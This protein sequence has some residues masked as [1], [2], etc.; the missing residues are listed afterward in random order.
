MILA[1]LRREG[2][3]INHKK[4]HRLWRDEG[5]QKPRRGH[6]KR[7]KKTEGEK[8]IRKAEYPNHVWSYDFVED[9]T[10]N[11]K[12]IRN[13]VIMDEFTREGLQIRVE[14]SFPARTVINTLEWLFMTRAVPEFI[15][16]D[17]GPEFISKAITRWLKDCGV[18]TL[19]I[20]PGSPWENGHLE[21]LNGTFRDECLNRYLFEN[22]AEAQQIVEEFRQEYNEFRPHSSLGYETPGAYARN[23]VRGQKASPSDPLNA[24]SD[25]AKIQEGILSLTLDRV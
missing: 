13:L 12:K 18:Q 21:S 15:R 25:S 7:R 3:R 10:T 19:F 23:W 14:N 2:S 22:L 4:M 8:L 11:G 5:L 20:E 24:H 1:I 9:S 17:N 16:S 6:G